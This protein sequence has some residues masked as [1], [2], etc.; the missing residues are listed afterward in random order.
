MV[1]V[2]ISNYQGEDMGDLTIDPAKG[3]CAF[4]SGKECWGFTLTMFAKIY[5]KK[6]NTDK[7]KMIEKLWGDNYYDASVKKWKK[8]EYD[9]SG[10]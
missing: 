8:N 1:N 9:E 10:K 6:F 3:N 2:I 4:G 7:E 5:A